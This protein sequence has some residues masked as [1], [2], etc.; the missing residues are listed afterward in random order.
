M[1]ENSCMLIPKV[2]KHI[3]VLEISCCPE[4]WSKTF[5]PKL[6]EL[7]LRPVDYSIHIFAQV[8]QTVDLVV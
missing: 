7:K 5:P 6:F 2:E 1:L 8:L 4:N 3:V